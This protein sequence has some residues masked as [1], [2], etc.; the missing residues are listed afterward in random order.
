M[1]A[2]AVTFLVWA[3]IFFGMSIVAFVFACRFLMAAR[4]HR[5]ESEKMVKTLEIRSRKEYNKIAT[6]SVQ[7]LHNFLNVIYARSLALAVYH[8]ISKNDPDSVVSL[9]A[10]ATENVMDY[11][12]ETNIKAIEYYYGDG[13]VSR[14]SLQTYELLEKRGIITSIIDRDDIQASSIARALGVKGEG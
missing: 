3:G 6:M 10:K 13:Y 7:E 2:G 14:W 5:L 8:Q 1:F 4:R 11:L 12:G 9:Y